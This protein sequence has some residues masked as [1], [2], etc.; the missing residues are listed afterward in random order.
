V[1]LA[2]EAAEREPDLTKRQALLTFVV[3]GGGPT[4]VEMAGALA[5]VARQT[6]AHDFRRIDST[7]TRVLLVEAAPWILSTFSEDL[8]ARAVQDLTR[9]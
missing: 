3:I 9:L 8:A 6:I 1:L 7:L 5:E 2:F 4:G